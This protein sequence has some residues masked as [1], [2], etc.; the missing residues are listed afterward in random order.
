MILFGEATVGQA[1]EMMR[2]LHSF[3]ACSGQK[4]SPQKSSV[5][6]S[7]NTNLE[8]QQNIS[9]A[10]G[11]PKVMDMGKYL[12]VPSFHGRL[13]KDTFAGILDR[14]RLKLAGWKANSLS[15][16]GRY[17]LAQAVLS[18]IPYYTMQ[19]TLLPNGVILAIEKM[20]R[21]FLWGSKEGARKCHL[22]KW[23]V[24]TKSKAYGGLG[25]RKLEPMNRAFLAKL[26][27]RII[28]NDDSLWV[29]IFKAKYAITS[30]DCTTWRPKLNMSNA[31]KDILKSVPLLV[32]GSKRN[33]RNGRDTSFWQEKWLG[34]NPL[35]QLALGSLSTSDL[36]RTVAS[37]WD[38]ERGWDWGALNSLLPE[39]ILEQLAAYSLSDD[40]DSSDSIGWRKGTSGAFSVKSA[41]DI[42]LGDVD[43]VEPSKWNSIWKL[44]V[45]NRVRTFIWLA[46]HNRLMTNDNRVRRG[47]AASDKCWFC[48][49]MVENCEH[50][51]RTC[52]LA[53]AL[54][55]SILPDHYDRTKLMP[56]HRWLEEGL[57]SKGNG[58]QPVN[59][60]SVFALTA[61]WAWKWRNDAIFNKAVKP[62][63]SKLA[64]VK[65]QVEEVNRAFAN[66]KAPGSCDGGRSWQ[67]MNWI[68]PPNGVV[69][70]NV[71]GAVDRNS[72]KAR[73]G[74]LIR[75]DLGLWQQG[76]AYSI[77][78]Y[79]PLEAEAWALLKGIQ[80]AIHHGYNKVIFESDSNEIT[81]YFKYRRQPA[82][83]AHNIL[84]ACKKELCRFEAWQVT[85]ITREQNQVADAIAKQARSLPRGMHILHHPPEEIL[86]L[87]DDDVCGIPIWRDVCNT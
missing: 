74:G 39:G 3:C 31:W 22:V 75:N 57:A 55:K 5:F 68:K 33:V 14:I 71:D 53:D 12:G 40:P 51:M 54:W 15:F 73:C 52:P 63:Q 7:K 79:S 18:A 24:I 59:T 32:N 23:D 9:A 41:Y 87:L 10:L 2:C 69:K 17:T 50:V 43:Q 49:N 44:K 16:A 47:M 34:D 85:L 37:Y 56:F 21:D 65:A 84:E 83:A 26:G 61:W 66:A 82:T 58:K 29:R 67:M 38:R 70:V 27:W 36:D 1:N 72:S 30:A 78:N 20:I 25:I 76:F 81:N 64:W 11:I 28:Q 46:K 77:G 35:N 86:G 8:L 19:T 6:F 62:L 60:S 45:P 48:T 80:L 42:D 4:I 13:M